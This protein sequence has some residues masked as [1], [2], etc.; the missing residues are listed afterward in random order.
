MP[1]SKQHVIMANR[2]VHLRAAIPSPPPPPLTSSHHLQELQFP[3]LTSNPYFFLKINK[4][5]VRSQGSPF[6]AR[7]AVP[8]ALSQGMGVPPGFQETVYQL[9]HVCN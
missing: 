5:F 2:S 4:T 9:T 1:G 8:E 6:L 7:N 3:L